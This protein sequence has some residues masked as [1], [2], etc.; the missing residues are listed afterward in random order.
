MKVSCAIVLEAGIPE[1]R[2]GEKEHGLVA[3]V[4]NGQHV[5]EGSLFVVD[6]S[7]PLG[8]YTFAHESDVAESRHVTTSGVDRIFR[9]EMENSGHSLIYR[10]FCAVLFWP[11]ARGKVGMLLS[12]NCGCLH[13]NSSKS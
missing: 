6:L 9:P 7:G 5:S 1:K 13:F 2:T 8:L 11:W 12:E 10:T 4:A 3:F